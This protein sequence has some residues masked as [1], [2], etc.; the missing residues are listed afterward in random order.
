MEIEMRISREYKPGVWSK[1]Q[2]GA[3]YCNT[4][5]SLDWSVDSFL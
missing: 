2:A 3:A 4:Y 5:T 1:G